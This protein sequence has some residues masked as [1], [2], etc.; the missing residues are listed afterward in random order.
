MLK[1]TSEQ[2]EEKISNI[3]NGGINSDNIEILGDLIDIHK[4]IANEKYW[5]KKEEVYKTTIQDTKLE[6]NW[7]KEKIAQKK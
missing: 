3:V 2:V 5:K 1:K 6:G 4:D 7:G